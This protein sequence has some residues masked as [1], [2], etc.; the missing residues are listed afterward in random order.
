MGVDPLPCGGVAEAEEAAKVSINNELVG[1]QAEA[2]EPLG[3]LSGGVERISRFSG[4]GTQVAPS[5]RPEQEIETD[6]GAANAEVNS[7][8]GVTVTVADPDWPGVRV[9]VPAVVDEGEI[10]EIATENSHSVATLTRIAGAD[11]EA[12]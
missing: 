4:V 11:V 5:G 1:G 6:I 2:G 12:A 7:T 3:Q 10:L 9:S 8:D